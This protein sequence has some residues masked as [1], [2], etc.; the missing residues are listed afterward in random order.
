MTTMQRLVKL[1]GFGNVQMAEAAVPVPRSDGILVRLHRS[2]I[3]RGSELFRRYV[4]EEAVRP[5]IMGYSAAGEV[6]E[7]GADLQGIEPGRRAM[8]VA[9]HAQYAARSPLGDDPRAFVLPEGLSY[10]A[11]TFLLL[12]RSAIGWSRIPAID[13]GDTVVVLGQGIVGLLYAQAVRERR[14][15]RV[16]TV[17]ARELRCKVSRQCGADEVIDVSETDSVDAVME[18]T[19]GKGADLVVECVGGTAGVKSFEQAQRMVKRGGV[20]HLIA[21]YQGGPEAGAGLLPLD[22]GIMQDNL[23]IV[24]G[25]RMPGTNAEYLREATRM[26]VDGRLKVDPII[27]HRMPWRQTPDAYHMLYNTPDEALGVILEWDVE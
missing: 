23:V 16:V 17:D 18:L 21:K 27:T 20:I 3:S 12:A 5:E 13:P 9:P 15:G 10:E 19:G 4:L 2:L 11:A 14:P 24:A 8:I 22:S 7:V 6:V 25:H 26:L 1:E